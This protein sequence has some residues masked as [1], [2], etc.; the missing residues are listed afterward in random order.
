MVHMHEIQ[1]DPL[2]FKVD[3][4]GAYSALCPVS[5]AKVSERVDC[6]I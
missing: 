5:A 1:V 3:P 6:S 4:A 2:I